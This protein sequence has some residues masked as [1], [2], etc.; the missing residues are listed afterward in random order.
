M[1]IMGSEVRIERLTRF[2]FNAPSWPASI[3]ILVVLGLAIDAAGLKLGEELRFLTVAFTLPAIAAFILTRPLIALQGRPMT[4]NRSALLA[5]SC[6]LFGVILTLTGVVFSPALLPLFY[7]IALG[8]IFSLRLVV[9][10]AIADYRPSRMLVPAGLQ[11]LAG[12]ALGTLLFPPFFPLLAIAL[13]L[14]FGA[15][16]YLFIWAIDRPL[17]RAFHIRGLEFLNA[18]LAHLTDGSR[19]LEDFFRAIGEEVTV[20][21]VTLF[22][23]REGGRGLVFTVPMVHPGPMGEI[24][25]G[26][27]PR[28]MQEAFEEMVMVPH[29]AATHDF[30][31]V[32]E[33]EIRKLTGAVQ[34]SREGLRYTQKASQSR[35]FSSGTVSV[36]AQAFGDT[37]LLVTTRSPERT[38]DLDFNIG[39]TIMA[40]GHRVYRQVAFIDAHNCLAGEITYVHPATR[41]AMEYM[42]ACNQAFDELPRQPQEMLQMGM[43][44]VSVP[45]TR[46]QGFGDQGL[47]LAVIR[48]GKQATAYLL[49]DGNNIS[50][51]ARETTRDFLLRWVDEAEVMSTDSHVVNTI[52]G[53]N[54]VGLN[55]PVGEI[56]PFVEEAVVM[57]L[58][59]MRPAEVSGSMAWCED[60]VIFGSHRI[61]QV[62]STVNTV[63][64]FIPLLSAGILLFAFLLSILLYLA[65]G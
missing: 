9:L 35:R 21:Q 41:Q 33:Q 43:A 12:A 34:A 24:G 51:G 47:Q 11:S 53:R 49:F 29:G 42:Q 27:L 63:L 58:Q 30:N 22:F 2:L 64:L 25:G 15:G 44:H 14:V 19:G 20:P 17:Y 6:T 36:L 45:F 62:A 32:S 5:L 1:A 65:I 40:E 60:V 8:L 50:P 28:C 54:P 18:F 7:A 37:L 3:I 13:L 39:M 4:W 10:V 31:L 56:L 57:A 46:E 59:D 48:A 55:V 61:S 16:A 38:E 26:N 23:R 52:S